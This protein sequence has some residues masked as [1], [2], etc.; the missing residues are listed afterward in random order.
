[1]QAQANALTNPPVAHPTGWTAPD[2]AVLT[3]GQVRIDQEREAATERLRQRERQQAALARF[4]REALV[5]TDVPALLNAAVHGVARTLG[6]DFVGI[7][8]LAAD[9]HH[10]LLRAGVGWQAGL[11]GHAR[12]AAGP[13][14]AAQELL[15]GGP[16]AYARRLEHPIFGKAAMLASHGC[17]SGMEVPIPGRERPYG[18]LGAHSVAQRDFDADDLAF[19]DGVAHTL[20]SAIERRAAEREAEEVRRRLEELVAE[21]TRQL[22][23]SNRELEAFSYSVSHDLRE[24]LRAIHGFSSLLAQRVGEVPGALDLLDRVR[25]SAARLGRLID[26]LLDLSRVQRADLVRVPIDLTALA[27]QLLADRLREDPER[28]VTFRVQPGLACR[29][30]ALLVRTLLQNLLGN[31]WK[32]TKA[33]PA[34]CI[35]VTQQAPG[36]PICVRDNGAG[37][38]M[39]YAGKLFRPFE[40]LH[41]ATEFEG[42]GIGLATVQR[43]AERHGGR[44]WAEGRPGHGAAFYFLL[45]PEPELVQ[46]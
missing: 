1:M 19:L 42:T 12:T 33:A 17:S 34:A 5:S 35:E 27:E 21:R 29:G 43:I 28:A 37:F 40:R 20:A 2:D 14:T 31:A 25:G 36:G 30:D 23:V 45:E 15:E 24:P 16:I 6:V 8:E 41:T 46:F 39:A 38:D 32:F 7:L 4:A 13:G 22:A 11:V 44:V 9:G 18:L 3:I 26:D 10:F